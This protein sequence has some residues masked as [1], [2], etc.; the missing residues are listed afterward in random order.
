MPEASDGDQCPSRTS[1]GQTRPLMTLWK[2]GRSRAPSTRCGCRKPGRL[3]GMRVSPREKLSLRTGDLKTQARGRASGGCLTFKE[4]L[5]KRLVSNSAIL[6]SV[7]INFEGL[8]ASLN[9]RERS[10]ADVYFPLF[11][12]K[13]NFIKSLCFHSGLNMGHLNRKV[14]IS[15]RLLTE[16]GELGKG[17]TLVRRGWQPWAGMHTR[18][19]PYRHARTITL[20]AHQHQ[21][22]HIPL[23]LAHVVYA[24][25]DTPCPHPPTCG[26]PNTCKHTSTFSWRYTPSPQP[27][28]QT[29]T[30]SGAQTLTTHGARGTGTL[31]GTLRCP[32]QALWV[33]M[34]VHADAHD[35]LGPFEPIELHH[36]KYTQV[37]THN[38]H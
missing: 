33:C 34:H 1:N 6:V 24:Q 8:G 38:S 25:K 16:R 32:F 13:D 12:F 23:P 30:L 2:E 22:P 36:H 29:K 18:T 21:C 5:G 31:S 35:I 4:E 20:T 7:L 27:Y 10:R 9:T 28:P 3:P 15:P 26:H 11:P 37:Q 17:G 19:C 14:I